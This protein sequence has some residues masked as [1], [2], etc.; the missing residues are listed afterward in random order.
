MTNKENILKKT[1]ALIKE[2]EN[3]F[4]EESIVNLETIESEKIEK[5]SNKNIKWYA[6]TTVSKKEHLVRE[7]ILSRIL[8]DGLENIIK[9]VKILEIPHYRTKD[10]DKVKSGVLVEPKYKNLHPGYI[11]LQMEMT[12]EAWFVVRNTQYVTGLVGS[13]GKRAKPTPIGRLEMKKMTQ[14]ADKLI[15]SFE[16]GDF[17]LDKMKNGV[18]V[19]IIDGIYKNEIGIVQ[20]QGIEKDT[21]VVKLTAFGRL[22]DVELDRKIVEIIE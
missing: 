18:Q 19:E 6:V 9:D 17:E 13:S 20:G 5:K 16:N 7:S 14:K 1:N 21:I 8:S 3:K 15:R 10:L 11:Y 22:R 2:Q 12:T 4:E